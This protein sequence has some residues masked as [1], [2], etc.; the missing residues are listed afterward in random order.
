MKAIVLIKMNTGDLREAFSEMKR[1]RS[2][3]EVHMIFGPYDILAI[4]HADDLK[5][6][7]R[8]VIREIQLIP[9][10]VD[11][12][13]CLMVDADVLEGVQVAEYPAEET[14][15][16]DFERPFRRAEKGSFGVN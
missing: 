14:Q 8:I 2:I 7:G 16:D 13:T 15:P 6:L 12:C 3:A 1:L 4:V 9:G 10:V 5:D 11:T